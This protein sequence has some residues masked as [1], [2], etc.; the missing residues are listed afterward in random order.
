MIKST[1]SADVN[2]STSCML[3]VPGGLARGVLTSTF[4]TGSVAT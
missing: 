2:T 3:K 1:K 4:D